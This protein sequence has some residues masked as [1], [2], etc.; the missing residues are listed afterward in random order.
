[1]QSSIAYQNRQLKIMQKF[2]LKGDL[3]LYRKPLLAGHVHYT[4]LSLCIHVK[5]NKPFIIFIVG[6]QRI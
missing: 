1:M 5:E 3:A 4:K 2:I 6:Q